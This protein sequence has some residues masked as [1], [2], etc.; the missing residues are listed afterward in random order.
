MSLSPRT[1]RLL[2]TP[3]H[4][5]DTLRA[6]GALD[7]A[8]LQDLLADAGR[9][10]GNDPRTAAAL[11]R[12][13]PT[14]ARAA[15]APAAVPAATYLRA[16]MAV[17]AGEPDIALELID[18][19][20]AAY[21]R[22]GLRQEALRT[23]L[24]RMHVLDDLGRH[25]EAVEVGRAVVASLDQQPDDPDLALLRA[26]AEGN[27][28]VALGFLGKHV[29]ALESYRRSEAAWRRAGRLDEAA[30]ATANQGIE[31]IALGRPGAA[32]ERLDAAAAVFD[33]VQDRAWYAKCLG[34]RGE[35]LSAAGWLADALADFQKATTELEAL[36]AWADAWRVAAAT[37]STFLGL[38]LVDEALSVLD[39]I[40]PRL[41]EK[42]LRHDLAIA[43]CTK[44]TALTRAGRAAAARAA[45]IE[46]ERLFHEVADV[47]DRA[48]ALLELAR[49][50][51]DDAE[52][53]AMTGQALDLL[54]DDAWPGIRCVAA[55]GMADLAGSDAVTAQTWLTEASLLADQL[56]LPQLRHAVSMRWAVHRLRAG[57]LD[58]GIDHLTR[59]LAEV[60]QVS[61]RIHD[62]ALRT[63]YLASRN[64]AQD[65]LI[66]ALLRRGSPADVRRANVLADRAKGRTLLD[67]MRGAV[68]RESAGRQDDEAVALATELQAAY[69]ALFAA[70]ADRQRQIRQ[71]VAELEGRISLR[72]ALSAG[73]HGS[74]NRDHPDDS[75]ALGIR[76]LAYHVVDDDVVAFVTHD[77]QR[78]TH[79]RV[80]ARGAVLDLLD[81]LDAHLGPQ[82]IAALSRYPAQRAK[83]CRRVL[84]ELYRAVFAPIEDLLRPPDS[85]RPTALLVV[86]H[87]LLHRVPFCALHNGREYLL[88]DWVITISPSLEV[89]Q[90]AESR[91]ARR[92][93]A[94]VLGVTD[95]ATPGMEREA[96]AI[97]QILGDA[98]LLTGSEATFAAVRTHAARARLVHLACHGLFRAENPTFTS[99][100]L[101]DRWVR[102][103]D[104][105]ALDL[106]GATLVLSACES[107]RMGR[108]PGHEVAGLARG[109][110]SA[111]VRCVV[112]SQWLADDRSTSELMVELYR[113]MARGDSPAAALRAAQL[114]TIENH[115][116]PYH[117]A[118][119]IAVGAP[120][121][122]G[123]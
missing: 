117:W 81:D 64:D 55:L 82:A 61:S 84:Q 78:W 32:I 103:A 122:H 114:S 72:H 56:A 10:I 25:T 97:A 16:R 50:A 105:T 104:V 17:Q 92:G 41:R 95:E 91:R 22:L 36:G 15:Q 70:D 85:H 67:I 20:R 107:G 90:I 120:D 30:A 121:H 119:F 13:V 18:E 71:T 28:G 86:P 116:H 75:P 6:E 74:W 39:G 5:V 63:A 62:E 113:S 118:P 106:A 35:A 52:A 48:R 60:R 80:A 83:A 3:T 94:L 66:S 38:G 24:G 42:G 88:R 89:A 101:A 93:S 8:G 100:R 27:A 9:L 40:E 123:G 33:A 54:A 69:S 59:A 11:L 57:D 109:F 37:A 115:P 4:A 44:G 77:G 102:A 23:A 47:P 43:L 26:A 34:H 99:F 96:R 73:A 53:R 110:L 12:L 45:L 51:D 21:E 31:L 46:A 79:R 1:T 14:L 7:E 68:H 98:T 58:S 65:E 19:A 108:L 87:G 76:V 111:G 2:Q 29:D 49:C 112:V